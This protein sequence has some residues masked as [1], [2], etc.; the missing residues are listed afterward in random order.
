MS[1]SIM[2]RISKIIVLLLVIF[3]S[4]HP[5]IADDSWSE[6]AEHLRGKVRDI[7]SIPPDPYP[8]S[9]Q[10]HNTITAHDYRIESISYASE[11]YSR[12]TALL[13]TPVNM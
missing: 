9:S 8:L 1:T 2:C 7:L 5:S 13:Y 10:I 6:C 3:Y 4:V 11:P 12:V